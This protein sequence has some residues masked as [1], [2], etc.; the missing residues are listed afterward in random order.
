VLCTIDIWCCFSSYYLFSASWLHFY[1]DDDSAAEVLAAVWS[2]RAQNDIFVSL[3][4]YELSQCLLVSVDN[5]D[6]NIE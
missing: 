5:I 6:M 4:Q 2:N 1:R 3:C